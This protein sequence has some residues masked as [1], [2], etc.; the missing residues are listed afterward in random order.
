MNE[1]TRDILKKAAY[2]AGVLAGVVILPW[3]A[4]KVSPFMLFLVFPMAWGL[5]RWHGNTLWFLLLP[6]GVWVI[7]YIYSFITLLNP[8]GIAFLLLMCFVYWGMVTSHIQNVKIFFGSMFFSLALVAEIILIVV[9]ILNLEI[10]VIA[11]AV[12]W[13]LVLRYWYRKVPECF[14]KKVTGIFVVIVLL[15][16]VPAIVDYSPCCEVMGA[17]A[18]VIDSFPLSDEELEQLKEESARKRKEE[19]VQSWEDDVERLKKMAEES[20]RKRKEEGPQEQKAQGGCKTAAFFHNRQEEKIFRLPASKAL[21]AYVE[22]MHFADGKVMFLE[23]EQ[24]IAGKTQLQ[25]FFQNVAIYSEEELTGCKD[26]IIGTLRA[27]LYGTAVQKG[28]LFERVEGADSASSDG[29]RVRFKSNE[30]FGFGL[31][32]GLGGWKGNR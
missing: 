12:G 28:M 32:A 17:G 18:Q 22:G 13:G 31:P 30:R 29:G 16:L 1:K 26:L 10:P 4:I 7:L 27:K 25:E 5:Y 2:L 3:L 21:V 15:F 9:G 14:S 24:K 20:A 11:I 6:G 23:S 8:F 19:D